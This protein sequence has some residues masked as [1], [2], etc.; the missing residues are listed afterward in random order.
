MK[1]QQK[2]RL[3][4]LL[5]DH[6]YRHEFFDGTVSTSIA[7]QIRANRLDRGWSQNEL[8]QRVDMKQSRISAMEDV[9]YQRWTIKTLKRL[10]RA[11]D[12]TLSVRFESFGKALANFESFQDNLVEH[13]FSKDPLIT[14]ETKTPSNILPYRTREKADSTALALPMSEPVPWMETIALEGASS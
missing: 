4:K 5:A 10:A 3:L 11:F 9:N 14:L 1:P 8:A 7:A 6:E 12:L 13:P 2:A